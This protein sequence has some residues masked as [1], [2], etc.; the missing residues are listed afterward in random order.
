[1][2]QVGILGFAEEVVAIEEEVDILV[3]PDV[4]VGA[5]LDLVEEGVTEVIGFG[6]RGG[7]RSGCRRK[8]REWGVEQDNVH[9]VDG[10]FKSDCQATS[11]RVKSAHAAGLDSGIGNI[12]EGI[13]DSNQRRNQ[14]GR[15]HSIRISRK[16]LCDTGSASV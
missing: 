14:F 1:M 4:R 12:A 16:G 2:I 8:W 15:W 5:G 3:E 9:E 10:R 6:R 7:D 13:L 11:N